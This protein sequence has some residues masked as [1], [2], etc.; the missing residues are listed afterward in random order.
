MSQTFGEYEKSV[1]TGDID[2]QVH[3]YFTPQ[4]T[5]ADVYWLRG[6]V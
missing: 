1:K 3:D 5:V 2:I 6:V 4:E